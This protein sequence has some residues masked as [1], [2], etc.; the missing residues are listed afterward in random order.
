MATSLSTL[1]TGVRRYMRDYTPMAPVLSAS[2]T[3]SATSLTLDDTTGI[4]ANWIIEIDYE[5]ILVRTVSNST[6]ISSIARGQFGSTAVSHASNAT[7]FVRPAYSSV[8]IID[9]LNGTKDEMYPYVYKAITDTS[10]TVLANTYEYTVPNMTGTYGGDTLP[11]QYI[12]RVEI[13]ESGD[14]AWRRRMDWNIKR[15]ATPKFIFRAV[16]PVGSA[17]RV[18]GYGPFPDLALSGDTVDPQF[19]KSA[20][21]VMVLGAASRLLGSAEAGRSRLDVGARDDREAANKPGN[22]IALG[23]QLERRFE[24]GLLR[25]AMGPIPPHVVSVF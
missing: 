20:E 4:A 12:S 17:I 25:A 18:F 11:I 7:V 19:P 23:N 15:V 13:K 22:A 16:P 2:I 1:V 3:S 21:K 9:A 24:K 10:L 6:T 14:Y 8:E 5:S